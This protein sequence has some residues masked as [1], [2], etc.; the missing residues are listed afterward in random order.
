[1]IDAPIQPT[2][3]GQALVTIHGLTAEAT[4]ESYCIRESEGAYC[5]DAL[6]L[7]RNSPALPALAGARAGILL[8]APARRVTAT[9]A[10]FAEPGNLPRAVGPRLAVTRR[11]R[12]G[13]RWIIAL[14]GRPPNA[15]AVLR[16]AVSYSQ[17]PADR[18][19]R[20][21]FDVRVTAAR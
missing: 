1:M 19:N 13:R 7:G 20:I 21:F 15:R 8:G 11:G 14:P 10:R 5:A 17:Y 6:P 3:P 4:V 16:F 9:M 18:A 2:S 12:T